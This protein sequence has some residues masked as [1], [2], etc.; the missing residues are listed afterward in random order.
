MKII[1]RNGLKEDANPQK[2]KNAVLAAFRSKDYTIED[3]TIDSIV[4]DIQL[5]DDISVE[6]IQNKF[7]L[8]T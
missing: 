5:W 1:K 3:S 4:K 7:Q 6:D 8:E 2:I